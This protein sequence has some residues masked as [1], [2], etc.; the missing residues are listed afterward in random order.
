MENLQIGTFGW[1]REE[2]LGAFYPEGLPED[3]R[4]DYFSNAFRVVLVPFSEWLAWEKEELETF[5]DAVE[6]DFYFYFAVTKSLNPQQLTQLQSIATAFGDGAAG[7]VVWSEEAFTQTEL[8]TLPVTLISERYKLSGWA[9]H[10]NGLWISGNPLG[11]VSE[12]VEDGAVQAALL[13]SFVTSWSEAS[14]DRDIVGAPF[15]VGGDKID[16]QRVTNLKVVGEFLGY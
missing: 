15:I 1:N 9:W 5:I 11:Y 4:L 16:M 6:G 8:A 2:W 3:W 13:K 12:L 7:V 14:F 10:Y